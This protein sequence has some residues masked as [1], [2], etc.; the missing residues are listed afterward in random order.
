MRPTPCSCSS[1]DSRGRSTCCSIWLGDK[2]WIWLGFPCS[3]W[4]ISTLLAVERLGLAATRLERA[5]DWLVMASWLTWL[6][7]RLLLP[8]DSKEADDAKRA[9]G[10]L[11]DRLAQMERLRTQVAWLEARPQLGRDTYVR[12]TPE[13][14][15]TTR[16][17]AADISALFEACLV[18]MRW[19]LRQTYVPPRPILRRPPDAIARLRFLIGC[20]PDGAEL[21]RFLPPHLFAAVPVPVLPWLAARTCPCN[22]VVPWPARWSVLSSWRAMQASNCNR[23]SRSARSWFIPHPVARTLPHQRRVSRRRPRELAV[24]RGAGGIDHGRTGWRDAGGVRFTRRRCG[25]S[26]VASGDS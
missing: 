5:A 3:C 19:P 22:G 15:T 21:A 8:Q 20:V 14:V 4:S 13:R 25:A 18:G 9:A 23:M 17:L 26:G 11:I 24:W 7:S 6:K 10:V 2:R 12:G 16:T 1:T